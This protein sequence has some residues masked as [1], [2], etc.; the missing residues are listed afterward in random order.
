VVL[1]VNVVPNLEGSLAELPKSDDVALVVWPAEG[2]SE[3]KE[4]A[5]VD[6]GPDVISCFALSFVSFSC[7]SFSF[8]SFSCLSFSCFSF[9]R[10]S[11]ALFS[12]SRFS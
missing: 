4:G 5:E 8:F 10:F 1:G 11:C 6:W 9:S 3:D 2:N 7:F 12:C